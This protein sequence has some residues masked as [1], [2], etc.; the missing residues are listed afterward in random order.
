MKGVIE[1]TCTYW[2][3]STIYFFLRNVT[4]I[5]LPVMIL[6]TGIG[7]AYFGM[8]GRISSLALTSKDKQRAA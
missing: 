6:S 1:F 4:R 2:Y 7:H 5:E 8:L 3:I